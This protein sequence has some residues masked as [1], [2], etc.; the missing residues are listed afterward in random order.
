MRIV[1]ALALAIGASRKDDLWVVYQGGEGAGK[2]KHIVLISGD[3]EYRSEEGLPQLGKILAKHHG[4]KCTVL[5]AVNKQTGEID[6]NAGD[7]IPGTEA[8]A[9]ADLVILAL[10]FR[11]LPPEQ[12]KPIDEYIN[13]GKPIIGMRT[14]THAFNT[15]ADDPYA[16]YSYNSKIKGWENGFGRQVLGETWVNHHGHHGKEST[17]GVIAPGQEKNPIV[18]GCE[19]IWGPTDVYTVNLPLP[20]GCTPVVMGQVL[21][22]MKPEDKPVEGKKND[23][24]MPVAWT[25]TWTPAEGK[26]ARIFTT[27]MGS[28]TDLAS[29]GLR[30]LVVNAAYWCLGMEDK[31]AER[32]K[33]DVVGEYAPTPFGFNKAKK[34]VKPSDHRM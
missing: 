24:M 16:K 14:A 11:H 17:R 23:P 5:F 27:T 12:M 2:G 3:E 7:N 25:K 33:V 19:D 30:R 4:F 29:E 8:V 26:K 32:A 21:Q 31:I 22:G 15:K 9:T 1:L 6:P 34:G 13:S 20:E 28:S 10:R 18:K